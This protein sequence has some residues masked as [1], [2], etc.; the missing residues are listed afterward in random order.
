[1]KIQYFEVSTGMNDFF[2]LESSHYDII[3]ELK[4]KLKSYD[5][6][7]NLVYTIAGL[8]NQVPEPVLK[9]YICTVY[10]AHSDT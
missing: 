9:C 5:I 3:E 8:R 7:M 10:R 4:E 6:D 2:E 1:M